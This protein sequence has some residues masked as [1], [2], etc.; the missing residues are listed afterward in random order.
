MQY[1]QH[2][3]II[4]YLKPGMLK[5]IRMGDIGSDGSFNQILNMEQVQQARSF[6]LN[7]YRDSFPFHTSLRNQEISVRLKNFSES[8]LNRLIQDSLNYETVEKAVIRNIGIQNEEWM[9]KY[10]SKN[11]AEQGNDGIAIVKGPRFE[12]EVVVEET[13]TRR[14]GL[15]TRAT[16]YARED[17]ASG[18]SGGLNN[19]NQGGSGGNTNS[20]AQSSSRLVLMN[21]ATWVHNSSSKKPNRHQPIFVSIIKTCY[22]LI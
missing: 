22:F 15:A 16:G 10:V 7:S 19:N 13:N 1:E 9:K 17:Y 14:K 3:S 2:L 11:Q 4:P 20:G 5:S 8:D 12:Y 21:R 18:G 6:K